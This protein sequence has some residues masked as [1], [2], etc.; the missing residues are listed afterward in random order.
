MR[1]TVLV[2]PTPSVDAYGRDTFSASVAYKGRFLLKSIMIIDSKGAEV[3]A[4]AVCYL[5]TEATS[6]SI[7]DK[8]EYSDISYRVVALEK[9]KDATR[10]RYIKT[11]LKRKI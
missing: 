8:L 11:T 5:P 6:L 9:P 3:Q 1:D 2:Y 10:E 4:D 7:N